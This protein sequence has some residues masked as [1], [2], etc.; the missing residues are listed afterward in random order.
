[1]KKIF[2]LVTTLFTIVF[3]SKAQRNFNSEISIK[4]SA[5]CEMCKETI[6][7]ALAFEKG[8]SK[9]FLNV[10]TKMVTVNYNST[11]TTPLKIKTAITKVGYDADE[12]V[13]DE[14]AYNKLDSCCKKGQICNDK[15]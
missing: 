11:K 12:L 1:M 10:E 7:N 6:E 9:A 15:K 5:V 14:K 8:I 4:T 3:I 2:L 13:A